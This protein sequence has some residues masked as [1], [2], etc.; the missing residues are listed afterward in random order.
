MGTALALF[1]VD[2]TSYDDGA[3][4]PILSF[5]DGNELSHFE[6]SFLVV[7]RL[8]ILES[9]CATVLTND[10]VSSILVSKEVLVESS[11]ERI[12]IVRIFTS[13]IGIFIKRVTRTW[14][15]MRIVTMEYT[16]TISTHRVSNIVSKLSQL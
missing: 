11:D 10:S 7:S 13:P 14:S 9:K 12:S 6:A 4:E 15:L 2:S 8:D 5:S 3:I 16:K 1:V